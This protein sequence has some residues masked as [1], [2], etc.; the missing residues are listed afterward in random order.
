NRFGFFAGRDQESA[1][2]IDGKS[3]W[4]FLGRRAAEISELPC[5]SVDIEC[6]QGAAG[7][8][9]QVQEFTVRRHMDV[10]RPDVVVGIARWR[11]IA[12]AYSAAGS[13][14]SERGV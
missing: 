3:A 10:R 13:A 11:S 12:C 14:R 9:G 2:G 5:L 7:A 4:L 8:L 1:L 6:R